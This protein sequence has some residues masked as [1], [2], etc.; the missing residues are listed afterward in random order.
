MQPYSPELARALRESLGFTQQQMAD[1]VLL[2]RRDRWSEIERGHAP[3]AQVWALAL[4][5]AGQHPLYGPC[6]RERS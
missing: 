4:I 2:G 6:V 1:A 3:S 5:V